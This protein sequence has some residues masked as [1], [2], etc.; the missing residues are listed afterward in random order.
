MTRWRLTLPSGLVAGLRL[1]S[2]PSEPLLTGLRG[3]GVSCPTLF[4]S[5][6]CFVFP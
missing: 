4:I 1:L 3:T 5:A 2:S 6:S